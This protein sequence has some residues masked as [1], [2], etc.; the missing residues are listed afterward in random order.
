MSYKL[1]YLDDKNVVL[2]V[3]EGRLNF[4]MVQ[5]YSKAALKLARK[6]NCTKYL[7]DHTGTLS[8]ADTFRLHTDGDTLEQF[9]F[10]S[11]DKLA[12][13][14]AGDPSDDQSL[15]AVKSNVK[16]SNTRYFQSTAEA[17]DWLEGIGD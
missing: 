17:M 5:Q 8:E 11:N 14:I 16:W 2:V 10:K 13:V 6:N 3:I 9:G 7:F 12:V 15:Q 4:D 1:N